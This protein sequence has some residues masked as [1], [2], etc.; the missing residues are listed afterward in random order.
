MTI[1]EGEILLEDA[2]ILESKLWIDARGQTTYE[3]DHIPEAINLSEDNWDE[4]FEQFIIN[5]DGVSTL[6]VYCD[7]RTCAASKGVAERLKTSLGIENV[8]V[9]KGGWETWQDHRN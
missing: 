9:L 4:Q 2:L 1:E 6:V 8:W 7:S 5:W 3:E